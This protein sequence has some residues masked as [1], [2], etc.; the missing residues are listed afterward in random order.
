MIFLRSQEASCCCGIVGAGTGKGPVTRQNTAPISV[1]QGLFLS[2]CELIKPIHSS[3]M[4][5]CRRDLMMYTSSVFL[6]ELFYS[7]ILCFFYSNDTI[8]FVS[9]ISVCICGFPSTHVKSKM[10]N[11]WPCPCQI[12]CYIKV[13]VHCSCLC[14]TLTGKITVWSVPSWPA[15]LN[16]L[17]IR[18]Y[19]Q[20]CENAQE[21]TQRKIC[22]D[23]TDKFLEWNPADHEQSMW[24]PEKTCSNIFVPRVRLQH[25]SVSLWSKIWC[26]VQNIDC[27]VL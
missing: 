21:C 10:S 16:S 23:V 6:I 3:L 7:I 24:P 5:Y 1:L 14:F 19:Q 13:S 25:L 17:T 2:R 4:A 26:Q 18:Y 12:G 15:V 11:M 27:I 8:H 22:G 9:S 20:P